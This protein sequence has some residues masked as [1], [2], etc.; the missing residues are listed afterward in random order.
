MLRAVNRVLHQQ[1][2]RPHWFARFKK[3]Q[4]A[5]VHL[6]T[7]QKLRSKAPRR[8]LWISESLRRHSSP[9]FSHLLT[10]FLGLRLAMIQRFK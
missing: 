9:L 2:I 6:V 1:K 3:V 8:G 5:T 10:F 4:E 7:F